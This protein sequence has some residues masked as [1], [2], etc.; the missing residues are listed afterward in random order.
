VP[1]AEAAQAEEVSNIGRV[2]NKLD[3]ADDILGRL[4]RG[5]DAEASE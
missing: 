1:P 3:Q 5:F 4:S 2:R